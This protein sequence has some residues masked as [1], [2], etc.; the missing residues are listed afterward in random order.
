MDS[1][2]KLRRQSPKKNLHD[3][4][5]FIKIDTEIQWWHFWNN[6][7]KVSIILENLFF[8]WVNSSLKG[9][10]GHNAYT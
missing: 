9:I 2:L 6:K 7:Q 8:F 1:D 4:Y 5:H 10:K 3:L